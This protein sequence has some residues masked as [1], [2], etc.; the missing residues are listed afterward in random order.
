MVSQE[1]PIVVVS[2]AFSDKLGGEG[3]PVYEVR[4]RSTHLLQPFSWLSF[5]SGAPFS[6]F[7]YME[8]KNDRFKTYFAVDYEE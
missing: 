3:V 6:Y 8:C 1:N 5:S 7:F 2:L 4:C